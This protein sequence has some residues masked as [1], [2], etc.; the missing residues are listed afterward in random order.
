[1]RKEEIQEKKIIV[2]A[3]DEPLIS[4]GKM[5]VMPDHL[6]E[7]EADEAKCEEDQPV[8]NGEK[9][10]EE[11]KV[12][13]EGEIRGNNNKGKGEENKEMLPS[14]AEEEKKEAST[15][16]EKGQ[17]S[18]ETDREGEDRATPPAHA[19]SADVGVVRRVTGMLLTV[20]VTVVVVLVFLDAFL[21]ELPED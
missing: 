5:P 3:D 10:R 2:L 13:K 11:T 7:S 9:C 1:M 20:A 16:Y 17:E 14:N 4:D 8:L 12:V 6:Q 15:I 18:H 21:P 19:G